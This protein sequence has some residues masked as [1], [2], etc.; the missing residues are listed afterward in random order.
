MGR[1]GR[2]R[3]SRRNPGGFASCVRYSSHGERMSW[4]TAIKRP[5][6]DGEGRWRLPGKGSR[7]GRVMFGR[8][9]TISPLRPVSLVTA[10]CPLPAMA[11]SGPPRD[12]SS[13]ARAGADIRVSRMHNLGG[14]FQ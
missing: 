2:T 4:A 13:S 3:S 6:M 5:A 7:T 1:E 11:R 14:H 10:V 8:N 9:G 12:R